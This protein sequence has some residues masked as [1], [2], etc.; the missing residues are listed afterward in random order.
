MMMTMMPLRPVFLVSFFASAMA[1]AAG[2]RKAAESG[3]PAAAHSHSHGADHG[4][5]HAH[6]HEHIPPHGGTAVVLGDETYHVEL[7]LDAAAG[8][9][10]A[11]ILDGH[12]DNFVRVTA[13]VIG[14]EAVV[15]GQTQVL[16]LRATA[17][18]ATGER[19]GDTALF[20]GQAEWLKHTPE[21]D[22][23]LKGVVIKGTSF[24][25]VK[26]NFPKGNE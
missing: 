7:V 11:Y 10:Q 14:L 20:E 4:H 15:G 16:E 8:K 13:P 12:M 5:S 17:N 3:A 9:L 22:G 26:F 25:D 6:D 23:V 19:V 18:S 24:T 21:F 2:C 1:L